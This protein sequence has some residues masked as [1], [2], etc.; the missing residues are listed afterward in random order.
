VEDNEDILFNIKLLLESNNYQVITAKN[1][2]EAIDVLSKLKENPEIILSDI[3]MPELDGYDFFKAISEDPRWGHIPF[4]FLTA[5]ASP[6]DIRFGKMLGIDD[7]ITKPFKEQDLLAV[8]SGKITRKK[9]INSINKEIEEM[10]L[11]ISKDEIV[12]ISD[13]DKSQVILLVV[14]WDDHLGPTILNYFPKEENFP[15]SINQVGQQ[16]FQA[17]VSIYGHELITKAEGILLNIE[18]I[19]RNGYILFDSYPDPTARS[20]KREYML[21]VIA[22]KISFFNSLKI[23]EIL[24]EASKQIKER[25]QLDLEVYRE[26]ILN[27]LSTPLI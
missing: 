16:L 6:K 19:R 4:L 1:G 27:L 13:A 15:F 17:T 25:N 23:K 5:K 20:N 22:P 11:S 8:I 21:G 26:K 7:Y 12:P 9:R 10:L 18:N 24:K 14:K 3:M 2:K